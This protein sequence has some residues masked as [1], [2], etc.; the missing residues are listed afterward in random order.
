M[1]SNRY[2]AMGAFCLSLLMLLVLPGTSTEALAQDRTA[3]LLR[4]EQLTFDLDMAKMSYRRDATPAAKATVERALQ[5][6]DDFSEANRAAINEAL[7]I[8]KARLT[9]A[10]AG[11]SFRTASEHTFHYDT[12]CGSV[13]I[14]DGDPAGVDCTI[15]V[16]DSGT[17]GDLDVEV[18]IL[19]TWID[20]LVIEVTSPAG[21][22]V[23]LNDNT[24]W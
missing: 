21:T 16:T 14:P 23:L 12:D 1:Q 24:C 9:P 4:Y 22:T 3:F 5:A 17:I 13:P 15:E 11:H 20:D 10:S 18:E 6:F 8:R 2:H 7:A 19:H